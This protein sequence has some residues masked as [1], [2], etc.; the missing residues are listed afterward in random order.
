MAETWLARLRAALPWHV[1]LSLWNTWRWFKKDGP[2]MLDSL[3]SNKWRVIIGVVIGCLSLVD[4]NDVL[5][6]QWDDMLE[7]VIG[8]LTGMGLGVRS[9]PGI[10]VASHATPAMLPPKDGK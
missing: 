1:K 9:T 10:P 6:T 2:T 7:G 4:A 8:L 5:P 3:F